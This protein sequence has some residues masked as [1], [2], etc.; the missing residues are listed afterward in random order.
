M[1]EKCLEVYVKGEDTYSCVT[2]KRCMPSPLHTKLHTCDETCFEIIRF[3][4]RMLG[5]H[6]RSCVLWV[7]VRNH[8]LEMEP[9]TLFDITIDGVTHTCDT[10]LLGRLYREEISRILDD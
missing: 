8:P 9:N 3:V 7:A 2:C 6:C 4:E 10:A 1:H 5:C